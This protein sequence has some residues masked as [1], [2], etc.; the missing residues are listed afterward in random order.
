[1]PRVQNAL[2]IVPDQQTRIAQ[3]KTGEADIIEGIIGLVAETLKNESSVKDRE[4]RQYRPA[5]RPLPWTFCTW[6]TSIQKD[7]GSVRR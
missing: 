2:N 5:D 1:M 6:T 3:I 4:D 7:L